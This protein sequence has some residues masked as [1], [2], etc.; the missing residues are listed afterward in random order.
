M[1]DAIFLGLFASPPWLEVVSSI[2]PFW[3]TSS[4]LMTRAVRSS[5]NTKF[6]SREDSTLCPAES[7]YLAEGEKIESAH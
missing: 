7:S 6:S 2:K 5:S 4:I 3:S 1:L